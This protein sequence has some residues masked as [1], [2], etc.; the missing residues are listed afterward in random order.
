M[1]YRKSKKATADAP[2][3]KCTFK[4]RGLP[5]TETFTKSRTRNDKVPMNG[6]PKIA[7]ILPN[8]FYGIFYERSTKFPS[9]QNSSA[10][11]YIFVTPRGPKFCFG[12]FCSYFFGPS[13]HTSLL[14]CAATT[15]I[16]IFL[17]FFFTDSTNSS[18]IQ[19]YQ[20]LKSIKSIGKIAQ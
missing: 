5:I 7:K 6:N 18:R 13:F 9:A 20:S 15:L 16:I 10:P 11:L 2:R 1:S 4:E 19:T 14:V 17:P 3:R 8:F 12:I